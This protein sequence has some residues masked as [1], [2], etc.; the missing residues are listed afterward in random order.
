MGYMKGNKRW[1]D[2]RAVDMVAEAEV[3]DGTAATPA[4]KTATYQGAWIELGDVAALRIKLA[5]TAASGTTPSMTVTIETSSDA[6]VSDAAR[7]VGA[8]AAKTGVATEFKCFAGCDR[9]VRLN[10]TISG[11]TPSF[12]FTCAGEGV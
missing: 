2:T 8:F 12:T 1:A 5:V 7:S 3:P 4:T 9:Y 11:T 6:G 10:V